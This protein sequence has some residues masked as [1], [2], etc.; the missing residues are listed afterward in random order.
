MDDSK[1]GTNIIDKREGKSGS[2]EVKPELL[3]TSQENWKRREVGYGL[4]V[5]DDDDEI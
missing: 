1:Y 3:N 2:E 5:Q 4:N